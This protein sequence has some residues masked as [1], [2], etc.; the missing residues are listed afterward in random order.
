LR[1]GAKAA[2]AD[3]EDAAVPE[4]LVQGTLRARK[5]DK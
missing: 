3:E 4:R 5:A 1:A 2:Y